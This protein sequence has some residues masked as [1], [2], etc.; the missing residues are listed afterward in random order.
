MN[1]P[2][3]FVMVMESIE[4]IL[5]KLDEANSPLTVVIGVKGS[6][7]PGDGE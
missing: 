5:Q 3:A 2:D 7:V 6:G 4:V 1:I